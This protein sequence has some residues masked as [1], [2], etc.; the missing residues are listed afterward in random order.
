MVHLAMGWL[1]GLDKEK[2][3][4]LINT[5]DEATDGKIFVEVE[6]ARLTLMKANMMEAEGNFEEAATLLQDVQVETYGAMEKREKTEYIMNQMRLVL[7]KKD[8]VRTQIIG[9]KINPT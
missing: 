5:L 8:Y 9:S 1:D 3:M 7:L 4:D 2:K 6:Q